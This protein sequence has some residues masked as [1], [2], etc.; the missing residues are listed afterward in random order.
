MT[1]AASDTPSIATIVPGTR[2]ST[3]G[4]AST[5]RTVATPSAVAGHE[6]VSACDATT[7]MRSMKSSG[8]SSMRRPKKSLS[9]VLAMS[10][11]MPL[12]KPTTTGRGMYLTADPTPDAP[13]ATSMMPAIMV[14]R[15]SPLT[16]YWPMMPATTTTNAPVGPPMAVIDPPSAAV[17]NPATIAQ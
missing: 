2:R 8:I 4:A 3:R 9:C 15:N 11:A 17:R 14:H 7:R 12:V 6:I 10:T 1:T 16:P 5:V 13:S